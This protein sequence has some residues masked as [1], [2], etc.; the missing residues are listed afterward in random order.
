MAYVYNNNDRFGAAGPFECDSC[1]ELA[2]SLIDT[3]RSYAQDAWLEL[4]SA[5]R[6][7]L[8]YYSAERDELDYTS[9]IEEKTA[10]IRDGFIAGLEYVVPEQ[11]IEKIEEAQ[12]G[13]TKM[14]NLANTVRRGGTGTYHVCEGLSCQAW[15]STNGRVLATPI[16][17][18]SSESMRFSFD[19]KFYEVGENGDEVFEVLG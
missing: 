15:V 2:D 3:F 5:E 17:E 18:E 8:D 12:T 4:Y 6:D 16:D 19:F 11:I 1:E 14:A 13:A 9:W 10:S 7:E